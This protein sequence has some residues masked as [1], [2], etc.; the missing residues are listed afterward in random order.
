MDEIQ[1]AETMGLPCVRKFRVLLEAGWF[2][3][4][5]ERPGFGVTT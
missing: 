4:G 1:H 3:F 2:L 5:A